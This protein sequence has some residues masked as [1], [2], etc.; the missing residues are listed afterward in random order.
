MGLQVHSMSPKIRVNKKHLLPLINSTH[1]H[2]FLNKQF[3]T[4]LPSFITPQTHNFS[5]IDSPKLPH[6]KRHYDHISKF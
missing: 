1:D 3:T 6:Q 5:P 4:N 2:I